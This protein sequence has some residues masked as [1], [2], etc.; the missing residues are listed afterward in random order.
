MTDY[1]LPPPTRAEYLARA[2]RPPD[3]FTDAACPECGVKPGEPCDGDPPLVRG[4]TAHPRRVDAAMRHRV[5][6]S[7]KGATHG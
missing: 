3:P 1:R 6:K 7:L 2:R 4:A 5:H